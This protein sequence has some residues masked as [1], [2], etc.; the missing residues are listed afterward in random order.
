[1]QKE[2]NE[3]TTFYSVFVSRDNNRN[4]ENTGRV[5]TGEDTG[6]PPDGSP[7]KITGRIDTS[8]EE[9]ILKSIFYYSKRSRIFLF[10]ENYNVNWKI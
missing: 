2:F 3:T 9:I 10:W 7:V 5:G 6:L 4:N 1:M 8:S